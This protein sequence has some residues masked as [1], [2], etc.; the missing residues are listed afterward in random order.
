MAMRTLFADPMLRLLLLAV[1]LAAFVPAIGEGREI[2]GVI[3]NAAIFLLFL[4]NGMRV[5]RREIARGIG[6]WRFLVPLLLWV[7]GAMA[8]AGLALSAAAV[9]LM[10]PLIAIGFLYLGALPSTVQSATS[11]TSLAGGNIGLS[12]VGAA[13]LNIAGIFVTVPIFLALGGMGEGSVGIETVRRIALILL[14]PFVIGQVVQ[15]WTREF[16]ERHKPKIVWVDRFVIALAVY[17]AFSGA[18]EQ[19]I[20]SKVDPV[21]WAGLAV[22]VSLF[23]V[24]GNWGAWLAG[25]ALGLDRDD[26]IAFLFAGA[27][28]S[29]AIGAPLAAILFEPNVAGFVVVPLLLYHLFQLVV[30]APIAARL[31]DSAEARAP[32]RAG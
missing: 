9:G 10:P 29:V 18:V 24:F 27:Q 15:G 2:A 5:P 1:I 12:V 13:L 3:V 20:W 6:N 23:L 22:L 4:L 19:G 21:V 30:A 26:R 14:L 28:K 25:G 11:Y 31:A 16:I 8:L 32:S 17:V 7:F